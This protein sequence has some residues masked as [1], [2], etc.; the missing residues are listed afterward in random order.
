MKEARRG[1]PSLSHELFES[2]FALFPSASCLS[3]ALPSPSSAGAGMLLED[4][5]G[6]GFVGPL[7]HAE[8]PGPSS[9]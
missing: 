8:L 1:K 4:E 6:D 2:C 5:P 3:I 9:V 7:C